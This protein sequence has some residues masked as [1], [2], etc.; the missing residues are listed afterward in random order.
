LIDKTTLRI[1]LSE[2]FGLFISCSDFEIFD[3]LDDFVV[4]NYDK[5]VSVKF[6]DQSAEMYFFPHENI[7]S[8]Q[9]IL[10][11]FLELP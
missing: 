10:E 2:K 11:S 8:L 5:K 1:H 9:E 7:E 3:L 4:A 6:L